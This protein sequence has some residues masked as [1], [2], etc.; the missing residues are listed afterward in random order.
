MAI[1]LI[2]HT[3]P[4]IPP[5]TCYG[6]SDIGLLDSFLEEAAAIRENLPE[7]PGRVYSSPLSRCRRLAE[8]LFPSQEISWEPDL[9]EIHC[10]QWE[11]RN[12]NEIP[13]EEI[14]PWM[15]NFVDKPIPGG[16]SY[17]A[18]HQRVTKAFLRI[19]ASESSAAIVTHGGV[20]RSILSHL[21]ETGLTDSFNRF[22]IHYG[23]IIR[24]EHP[25]HSANYEILFNPEPTSREWHKP[26]SFYGRS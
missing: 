16:E 5:G 3:A 18:L 10:G 14:D 11:L 6:Q 13:A 8:F 25:A 15:K 7:F 17:V 20:I 26:A 2:R 12:W 21:T 1:W 24:V 4:D 9:M 22:R 23:C 19:G